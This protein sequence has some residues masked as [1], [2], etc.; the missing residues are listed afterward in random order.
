MFTLVPYCALLLLVLIDIN[1]TVAPINT[2][3]NIWQLLSRID[4]TDQAIYNTL[5]NA[6]CQNCTVIKQT[7]IPYT[8]ALTTGGSFCLA[9]DITI[10]NNQTAITINSP[11]SLTSIQI[12]LNGYSIRS[13]D[14]SNTTGIDFTVSS[15]ATITIS[16]GAIIDCLYGINI[17]NNSYTTIQ[18]CTILSNPVVPTSV[19]LLLDNTN[20]IM[21][22]NCILYGAQSALELNN[23][24]LNII[25]KTTCINKIGLLNGS[26]NNIIDHCTL[27]ND[28]INT[29]FIDSTSS[30]NLVKQCSLNNSPILI[31]C[32]GPNNTIDQCTFEQASNIAITTSA[33]ATNTIIN[34]STFSHNRSG[35][36][37]NGINTII[38]GTTIEGN[39]SLTG[40]TTG[41][42][43]NALA[44]PNFLINNNLV[45]N[46]TI[47][48]AGGGFPIATIQNVGSITTNNTG[49]WANING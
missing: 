36:S 47:N 21:I 24:N 31:A 30:F 23:A 45:S 43:V 33:T 38:K 42:N 2:G 6:S 35:I 9:E 10:N 44:L 40:G 29:I 28:P 27:L 5:S 25:K 46:H 20:T 22:N 12:N 13:T 32:D 34:N 3:E 7:D 37:I 15:P 4:T 14:G 18:N 39:G 11:S 17:A 48:Y 41:I 8:I 19:G 49:F 1:G 26:S 16:N